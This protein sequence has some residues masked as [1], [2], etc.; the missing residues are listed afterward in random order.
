MSDAVERHRSSVLLDLHSEND[1][2][3]NAAQ[4]ACQ[5]RGNSGWVGASRSRDRGESAAL[6]PFA[7]IALLWLAAFGLV[8]G[9]AH[10][11]E[12]ATLRAL[13]ALP[14]AVEDRGNPAKPQQLS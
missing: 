6:F 12:T 4:T 8:A 11:S 7:V 1:A 3:R 13:S 14:Q 2:N 5:P 9:I 10:G